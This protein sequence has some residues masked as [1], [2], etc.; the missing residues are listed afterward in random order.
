MVLNYVNVFKPFHRPSSSEKSSPGKRSRLT[1]AFKEIPYYLTVSIVDPT[2]S[3]VSDAVPNS[4]TAYHHCVRAY[5]H[6]VSKATR[7]LGR[8]PR[9]SRVWGQGTGIPASARALNLIEKLMENNTFF[10]TIN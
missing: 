7:L 6:A 4:Q 9:L 5:G 2:K 1:L 10:L 3:A 8:S